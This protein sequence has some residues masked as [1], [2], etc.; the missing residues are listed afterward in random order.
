VLAEDAFTDIYDGKNKESTKRFLIDKPENY[1]TLT[2]K[3]TV[4]DSS[5]SYIVEVLDAKKNVLQTDVVT[6]NT[7]VI[8]RNFFTGKYTI[9]VTYDN[10]KNGKGDSGNVKTKAYAEKTWYNDKEFTLRPNWEMEEALVIP[11]EE[12][13]P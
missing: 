5:K 1:G 2:L 13:T 8:Y 9:R 7:A 4:P 11:K 6:K 12:V 3:V 10:N